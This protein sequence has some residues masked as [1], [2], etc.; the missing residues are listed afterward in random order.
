MEC[1]RKRTSSSWEKLVNPSW[2]NKERQ[3]GRTSAPSSSTSAETHTDQSM[4]VN[5]AVIILHIIGVCP[6]HSSPASK[7]LPEDNLWSVLL[8]FLLADPHRAHPLV[9][10]HCST[11]PYW[12]VSV[13]GAGDPHTLPHV[14]EHQTFDFS[15]E[16]L[17]QS[18]QQ[19]VPTFKETFLNE[20]LTDTRSVDSCAAFVSVRELGST[21]EKALPDRTMFP[22]RLR[23]KSMSE[24]RTD[25]KRLSCIPQWSRP[26]SS[27][28]KRISGALWGILWHFEYP[29]IFVTL[30][31]QQ[32]VQD[33]V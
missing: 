32:L 31:E 2:T 28:L 24:L 19:S 20:K 23:R 1:L 6:R 11:A 22:R 27:G 5:P 29:Y 14:R 18:R 7:T 10:E 17:R 33:L 12:E 9:G 3:T 4:A 26:I 16:S 15:L 21:G 8:I 25:L 30:G 13:L